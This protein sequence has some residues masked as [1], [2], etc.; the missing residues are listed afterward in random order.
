MGLCVEPEQLLAGRDAW[1]WAR[2]E[3]ARA[4][5]AAPQD[6]FGRRLLCRH[7]ERGSRGVSLQ[8]DGRH[9]AC[10]GHKDGQEGVSQWLALF[11]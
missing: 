8:R 7:S 3:A 5:W 9:T 11:L 10:L 4:V 1:R 2:A 6:A